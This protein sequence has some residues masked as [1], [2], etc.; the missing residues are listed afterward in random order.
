MYTLLMEFLISQLAL[1]H[2]MLK[3]IV[4]T[5]ALQ[6]VCYIFIQ[7]YSPSMYTLLMKFL[8]LLLAL[9]HSMLR[10]KIRTNA[11]QVV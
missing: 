10:V 6:V 9:M 11:L 8:I 7:S 2:S 5:N 4:S 1:M 3:V